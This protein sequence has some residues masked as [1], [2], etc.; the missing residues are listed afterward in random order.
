MGESLL[1]SQ[2][3]ADLEVGL[4]NPPPV[5]SAPVCISHNS[6]RLRQTGK[7]WLPSRLRSSDASKRR[8][9]PSQGLHNSR[10][11]KQVISCTETPQ[12]WR[13]VI[14]LI[15]LN[16]YLYVPTFKMETAEII[17]NSLTKGEWVVSIDL[18]DAYF[19]VPIHP[20]SQHLLRFHVDKRTYQFK[21]LPF[22]L[23]TAPLEFTRIAKEAKLVL[24][25]RGIRVHQYLDDWLLRASSQHQCMSQTKELLRTVQELGFVINFEK[26]ELEPTQKI[27]FLGYHFDLLQGKVFPTEKKLKIL[28]KAVQ[29]ME[30]VSQTTPRLLMSLIGVLASLEKTVPMGRLHM[31]PFQWYLKTHWQYPQSLD[32][33]IPVSNLLKSFLQWWKNPKN[34]EKGCPLHPQEHNTL[35]FTDASNQGW[36]A[37]LENLT[38]SGNWTD[39]EKLLHINVLELKA[40]FLA[41]KSFQNRILDK[42][43]LIATDNATV[44][45]Y[46]NKQ[47]GTHSWD[48]CLLVWRILAYCN[49]RNILIRAR[50]IQGCLNVIADSLSRKDKIIQTEWSLHPQMF[51]RIC[52]VWHTPMVD[53]FATKLNHKLPIYVSPVPDANAMNIDALNISWEGLDGYAFCPVALI[54]K[55]IQK[56]NTYRCRMIV[57]APGWPMMHWFWD[58]VN[59]STK[60]PL[61]LPHWPHLLKQPFSHKYH[62]NLL[63]LN[64]HVWHLDTTQNHLNH[65]LS[66]WQRELRHLKDPH[67]EECTNQG[68]PFFNSGAN[69]VR[70]SAQSLLSQ[71]LQIS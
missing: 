48:M 18:K 35:I 34:L 32:L 70:W 54:P 30:V 58:L 31:R 61:Q 36:G 21:A 16:S 63:Y 42:R 55:V 67:L 52:K 20:D 1:S 60:P 10:F 9:L 23:A 66:R 37:H 53:M 13:P 57:V 19:H 44:V 29:D 11:L 39:Q 50:H 24:Q 14:D 2:S 17:R 47:G 40:V 25:S 69:R 8:N 7:T 15:V 65:S 22:G 41:L 62:Q 49:P 5:E 68:G 3:C 71:K 64:L 6:K 38:V 45:S 43:V 26:S 28:A 33:K 51:S 56:M 12:K 27:D 46:L 59:L 4:P